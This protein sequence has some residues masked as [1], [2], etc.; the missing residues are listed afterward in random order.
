MIRPMLKSK[1]NT[2]ILR[3]LPEDA[4]VEEVSGIFEGS[5][6]GSWIKKITPDVNQTWFVKFDSNAD[7]GGTQDI[8]LWLR[9]QKFRGEPVNAAIKSEHFLRSFF[10]VNLAGRDTSGLPPDLGMM[11]A[12]KG[13]DW[14]MTPLGGGQMPQ[15]EDG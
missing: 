15:L 7:E 13:G 9:S 4:T 3:G 8:V 12:E 11:G 5:D 10:P 14:E 1:R 6:Y 2:V